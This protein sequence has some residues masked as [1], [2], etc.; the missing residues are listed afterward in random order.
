MKLITVHGIRRKHRWY[1]SIPTFQE[2]KDNKIEVF[3]FDYG[4]FSFMKFLRKSHRDK[5]ITN[6]CNFYNDKF[7]DSKYPPSVIAHS[8]GTY[9]IYQAMKK[10]DVIK[11][12]KIIFCGSILNENTD[13]RPF[14]K[15][16]QFSKLKNDH[17]SLEWFLSFTRI[18]IDKDC[19]E[20]GKVGFTDIPLDNKKFVLNSESYKSHSEYFLPMHMKENWIKFLTED[21]NKFSY[22]SD[23]L[24]SNIIERIYE[25]IDQ[26]QKQVSINSIKYFARIDIEG[27]YFAKYEKKGVNE[28]DEPVQSLKFTTTADG[29]HDATVMNFVVYDEQNEKLQT[30]IE[31][32][33]NNIKV[34][35]IF[36]NSHVLP[37]ESFVLKH[38]FCWYKTMNLNGDTDHW[39]IKGIRNVEISLNFPRELLM[40][41]LFFVKEKRVVEQ[42]IPSKKIEKDNTITYYHK[43]DNSINND[44]VIFY[45]EGSIPQTL[46]AER[47]EKKIEFSIRGRKD[48]FMVTKATENDI[49][50]VYKIE[51]DIELGNAASELTLNQRRI[52][53]NDG[54]LVVKHKKTNRIV[55]YIETVIWN[56]K[57]FE[58][59]EEI[60]NFPL[61]FNING[62]SMYVIFIAV[63]NAFRKMGIAKRML[64]EIENVAKKYDISRITLV[65]KDQLF[66]L[67]T[68]S[69]YSKVKE[70]PNFLKEKNYKSILMSK[71]LNID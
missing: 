23:L 14:I 12:D 61:H 43:Y 13:F 27:N 70:L 55:G 65:A 9:I 58:N 46:F 40:T 41:K 3:Y 67:Y 28:S 64:I 17:G 15:R 39:S 71:S 21:I 63:D 54:F 53:F 25:N 33:M 47:G 32:D 18:I 29:F 36:L 2:F 10:Y 38:Y 6:F 42:L 59:F 31:K 66:D 48:V 45:F 7:I 16:K 20:A 1:E 19:G 60:S 56:E 34:F 37:K 50:N 49:K 68:K 24:K 69:K 51:I 8:F 52:M 4:Y 57:K 5:I 62:S 44:G 30:A 26:S 22:N 35:K 11:F